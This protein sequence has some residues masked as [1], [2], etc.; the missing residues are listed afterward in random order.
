MRVVSRHLDG[1]VVLEPH[2]FEDERGYF[3]ESFRADHFAE[4]GLPSRFEQENHSCSRRGVVRGLHFQWDPPMGK[5]MRVIAGRAFLV[6]VDIRPDSPTCGR[7]HGIEVSAEDGRQVWA[8]AWFARGFQALAEGTEILYKCTA[9][10]DPAGESGI[11]WDDPALGIDWPLPDEAILSAKD[12]TA[13]S[14]SDWMRR[15]EAARFQS[16]GSRA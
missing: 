5:L 1:V 2:R 4:A 9:T 14:L 13:V 10:Y 15:P 7:W 6:A 3:M 16:A 12:R 11:R 8:P